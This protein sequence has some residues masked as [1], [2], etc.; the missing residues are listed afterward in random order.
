MKP[1]KHAEAIMAWAEGYRVTASYDFGGYYDSSLTKD[2]P[3][4]DNMIDPK[5]HYTEIPKRHKHYDIIIKYAFGA[6]VE[7]EI[8][9]EFHVLKPIFCAG[10]NY[11]AANNVSGVSF[12]KSDHD[13]TEELTQ[14][15]ALAHQEGAT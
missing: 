3:L 14:T 7:C 1:H 10:L 13:H 2:G 12:S 5:V 15:R 6:G 11:R 8:G 9:G 4:W